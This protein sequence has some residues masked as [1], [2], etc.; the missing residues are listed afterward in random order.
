VNSVCALGGVWL[1]S[2]SDDKT[3]RVWDAQTGEARGGGRG[4]GEGG[5]RRLPRL[6]E[7]LRKNAKAVV[8]Q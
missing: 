2:G 5:G 8:R 3:V 1:A 4:S 7:D 6:S